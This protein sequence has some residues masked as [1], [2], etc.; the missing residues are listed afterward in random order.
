[1]LINLFIG[2]ATLIFNLAILVLVVIAMLRFL[3]RR[4]DRGQV[5]ST[6]LADF[7][8]LNAVAMILFLGHLF[9]SAVWATVF[10]AIGEFADYPTAFYHSLVNFTSLGYG[11]V[12]MSER[13]RTLGAL[14]AA[15]GVMMFGITAGALLSIMNRIFASG[16]Y[17]GHRRGEQNKAVD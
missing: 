14:E 15:N 8:V 11:D 1:M 13:W 2:S 10:I 16:K 3:V 9:Q 4:F 7:G 6:L 12:V 17:L 5:G